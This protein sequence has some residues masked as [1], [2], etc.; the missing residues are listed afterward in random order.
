MTI[1]INGTPANETAL[2]ILSEDVRNGNVYSVGI[3]FSADA[4]SVTTEKV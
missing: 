4:V 2:G 1:Y 3:S